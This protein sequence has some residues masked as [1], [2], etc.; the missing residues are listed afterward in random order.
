MNCQVASIFN[1][2]GVR[3]YTF[4]SCSA[5][6]TREGSGRTGARRAAWK[7]E[8]SL[9]YSFRFKQRTFVRSMVR[10][11]VSV[12]GT[13]VVAG[14]VRMVGVREHLCL[15]IQI[16]IPRS[17]KLRNGEACS[18]CYWSHYCCCCSFALS[19]RVAFDVVIKYAHIL[20]VRAHR[21]LTL[22][23]TIRQ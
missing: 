11:A 4:Y 3:F 1:N 9:A 17:S 14:V 5:T 20:R 7:W 6:R 10:I 15:K 13:S 19:W 12:V 16:S 23:R 21:A 2:L 22:C 18:C 8:A